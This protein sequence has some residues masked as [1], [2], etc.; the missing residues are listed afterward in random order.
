MEYV[1]WTDPDVMFQSDLNAST[2]PKPRL[3]SVS[4]DA[5]H[6]GI[7]E[8]FG[9]V[10]FNVSAYASVFQGVIST[11]SDLNWD[12]P[13]A[14]QNLL[15]AHLGKFGLISILPKA[16]NYRG[17]WGKPQFNDLSEPLLP[18][19]IH[20]HGPKP[21]YTL[22]VLHAFRL[23]H[24]DEA[25]IRGMCGGNSEIFR[26][27]EAAFKRDRGEYFKEIITFYEHYA[28]QSAFIHSIKN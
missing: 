26:L 17:Y 23:H 4:T 16:Y 25:A 11:G 6:H 22:C 3:L 28:H 27:V 12:F 1:L 9:V 2:L 20:F 21:A 5:N 13:I 14:D 19:I 15:N 7:A 24:H 8:N 10:Y 18:I